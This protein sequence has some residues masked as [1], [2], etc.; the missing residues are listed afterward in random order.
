MFPPALR[1]TAYTTEIPHHPLQSDTKITIVSDNNTH[2]CMPFSKKKGLWFLFVN[3]VMRCVWRRGDTTELQREVGDYLRPNTYQT[4]TSWSNLLY[5]LREVGHNIRGNKTKL[6][7]TC[8]EKTYIL[9]LL[10]VAHD[11]LSHTDALLKADWSE[12]ASDC[13]SALTAVSQVPHY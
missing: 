13:T 5:T 6:G 9:F 1:A 12:D 7:G 4:R 10:T 3:G 11:L 8:L 2:S